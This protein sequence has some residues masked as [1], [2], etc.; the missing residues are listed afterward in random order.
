MTSASRPRILV[1]DDEEAIL[2]TM[3]FTFEDEYEVFTSTD[4]RRALDI[5]E[6]K[7]PIAV[8]LSDQ[9]MPNMSG[10]EFVTEVCKRHPA[11]VRMILTGFA[12]MDAIIQAINAGHV[13]A[14]ISKPWEPDNLKQLMK[15][16]VDRYR[17]AAENERLLAELKHSTVFLEAMMDHL[18]TGAIAVDANGRVEA[19]NRPV[20]EYLGLQGDVRGS[21]LSEMLEGQGLKV[22]GIAAER[23]ATDD[24]VTYEDVEVQMGG[25]PHRF[26][27]SVHIF[28]GDDGGEFGKVLL[29]REVSHEPLRSRFD[30]LVGRLADVD[31]GLREEL[32]AAR[33]QLKRLTDE[34]RESHVDS[35]GMEQLAERVSRTLTAIE[36]WLDVDDAIGNEDF[37]D[38][39]LLIDRM[40]VATSRWPMPDRLPARV[41]DLSRT[42][43]QYYESGENPKQHVL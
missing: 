39:Q 5:L 22:V 41:R 27:I 2:E 25:Q 24:D 21:L 42:V 14:Y 30:D 40:R 36:N 33:A 6:E 28:K 15:Q 10:V 34:V 38:A 13:Y 16:A 9:R 12:D 29:V 26:R 11:T 31:G 1:V 18:D 32:E 43:D 3:S 7:A 4:A 8:V 20:R 37:P 19:V 23:I 17:L 35:P